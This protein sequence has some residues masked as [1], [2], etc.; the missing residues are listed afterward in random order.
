MASQS[1]P[2]RASEVAQLVGRSVKTV[3][4]AVSDGK[5]ERRDDGRFDRTAVDC[6]RAS[7]RPVGRPSARVAADDVAAF[8]CARRRLEEAKAATA[9]LEL[10]RLRGELVD[11]VAVRDVVFRLAFEDRRALENWATT[12]ALQVAAALGIEDVRRVGLVLMDAVQRF[13]TQRADL[14][15]PSTFTEKQTAATDTERG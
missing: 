15:W 2:L 12:G 3:R 7:V 8:R 1:A 4:A 5:L 13:L 11:H 9:E 6:W 10:R 14:A